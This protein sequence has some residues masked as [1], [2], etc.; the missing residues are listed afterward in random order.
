MGQPWP[1]FF[2]FFLFLTKWSLNRTDPS[3]PLY[4]LAHHHEVFLHHSN[5]GRGYSNPKPFFFQDDSDK[6]KD[7]KRDRDSTPSKS[8]N[9]SFKKDKKSDKDKRKVNELFILQQQWISAISLDWQ[10]QPLDGTK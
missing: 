4:P 3:R 8:S 1:L 9:D 2:V 7:R 6:G 10:K 5:F